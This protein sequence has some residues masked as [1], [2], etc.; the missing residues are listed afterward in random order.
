MKKGAVLVYVAIDQGGSFET[1]KPTTH[2]DPTY[3]IDG[4][5]HVHRSFNYQTDTLSHLDIRILVFGVSL[6]N[7]SV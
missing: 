3:V 2:T 4:V 6:N 7:L 5:V 1:S